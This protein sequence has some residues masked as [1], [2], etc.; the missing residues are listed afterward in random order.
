MFQTPLHGCFE[1][2]PNGYVASVLAWSCTSLVYN[3]NELLLDIITNN[4]GLASVGAGQG[5]E[6]GST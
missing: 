6:E 3:I 2:R 4:L 1:L 5:I